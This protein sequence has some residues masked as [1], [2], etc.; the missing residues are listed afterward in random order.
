MECYVLLIIVF[1]L[2]EKWSM[3]PEAKPKNDTQSNNL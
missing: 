1:Q 3:E 2:F